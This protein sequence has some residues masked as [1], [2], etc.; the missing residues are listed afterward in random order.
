MKDKLFCE[1]FPDIVDDIKEMNKRKEQEKQE[2]ERIKSAS[3]SSSCSVSNEANN[4]N[5]NGGSNLM[6][7]NQSWLFS[8]MSNMFVMIGLAVFAYVVKNVFEFS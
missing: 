6:A 5:L 3:S 7:Q 8:V 4:N 2:A 1:L